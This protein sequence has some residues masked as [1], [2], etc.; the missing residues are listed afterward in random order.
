[1][2]L[3]E[4]PTLIAAIAA[5]GGP[6]PNAFVSQVAIVRGSL[7]SPQMAIVDYNDIINGKAGDI[8]LEPHDIVFVPY[9]PYRVITRYLDSIL[10]TFVNTVAANEGVNAS[11]G[12]RVG[13]SV[14]VG[15]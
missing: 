10:S 15:N 9:S 1:M 4:H 11:G 13:V 14:P 2:T 5:G 7:T 3:S 8:M 12:A 6:L